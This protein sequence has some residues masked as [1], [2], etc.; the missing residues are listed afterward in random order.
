[1]L[2]EVTLSQIN[3]DFHKRI[4]IESRVCH[5]YVEILKKVQEDGLFQQQKEYKVDETGLLCSKEILYAPEGGDIRSNIL[6][7]FH[8]KP[9]SRIP[10]YQNMTFGVKIH[11]F[12]SLS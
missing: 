10:G 11:F 6:T 2:Y 12:S 5:F 3:F 4:R 7:E 9:Y 8:Q 1:M